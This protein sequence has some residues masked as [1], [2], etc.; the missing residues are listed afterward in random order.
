MSSENVE[1]Y[2]VSIALLAEEGLDGPVPLARLA[3]ELSVQVV[4]VNQMVRKLDEEGLVNYLPYKGVDL[5]PE[6]QQRVNAI[7]RHRRLWEVFFVEHLEFSP[8]EAEILACRMEHVTSSE[9][10]GRLSEFLGGPDTSP[11]GKAIPE[12]AADEPRQASVTLK[13]LN[14]GQQGEILAFQGDN[15]TTSFLNNE[16]LHPG[17]IV[18]IEAKSS[19]GAILVHT[20]EKNITITS[21]IAEKIKVK[22]AEVIRTYAV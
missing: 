2:L 5:T 22:A 4:S 3:D 9:V 18:Q 12:L 17:V 21:E 8:T 15:V 11:T 14:V 6:G 13:D 19:R 10:D 1:M 20:A 16:G 7:L